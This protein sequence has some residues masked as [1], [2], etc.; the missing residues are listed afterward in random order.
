MHETLNRIVVWDP[1]NEYWE[2]SLVSTRLEPMLNARGACVMPVVPE[3][4]RLG[5][6]AGFVKRAWGA[7]FP[8]EPGIPRMHCPVTALVLKDYPMLHWR[9]RL[10]SSPEF[11]AQMGSPEFR[12]G[13]SIRLVG[14]GTRELTHHAHLHPHTPSIDVRE[15]GPK[16]TNNGWTV[17]GRASVGAAINGHYGFSIYGAAE[18]IRVAWL[19]VTFTKD[20]I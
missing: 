9:A 16:D 12:P 18:G 6:N 4:F 15:L 13:G 5:G 1:K 2:G 3:L 7:G 10:L 17:G 14:D 19:A 20:G 8:F 11:D